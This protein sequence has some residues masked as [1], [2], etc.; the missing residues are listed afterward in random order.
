MKKMRILAGHNLLGGLR[1]KTRIIL[2]I[3]EAIN[4]LSMQ[5]IA[6]SRNALFSLSTLA[7]S[8]PKSHTFAAENSTVQNKTP[9]CKAASGPGLYFF[10]LRLANAH[11][12]VT[13][14]SV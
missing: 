2:I 14:F 6:K 10:L 13:V 4:Y 3:F 7:T 11:K 8:L 9:P 1:V 5:Q 12:D